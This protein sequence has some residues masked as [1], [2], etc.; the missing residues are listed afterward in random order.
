MNSHCARHAPCKE[1]RLP[2]FCAEPPSPSGHHEHCEEF[3]LYS[4]EEDGQHFSFMGEEPSAWSLNPLV[5]MRLAW[6]AVTLNATRPV[7]VLSTTCVSDRFQYFLLAPASL[8]VCSRVTHSGRRP[9]QSTSAQW[10][11]SAAAAPF[12]PAPLHLRRLTRLSLQLL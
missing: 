4:P 9:T 5:A 8:F 12:P 11:S 2:N 7:H 1:T 3:L 10:T 6:Y